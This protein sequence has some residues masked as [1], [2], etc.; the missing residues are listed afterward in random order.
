MTDEE[1]LEKTFEQED[2]DPFEGKD[3]QV[4][5]P[6]NSDY[7]LTLDTIESLRP[8][9]TSKPNIRKQPFALLFSGPADTPLDNALYRL[10][11]EG[12]EPYLLYID[13][14]DIDEETNR[15][16]YEAIVN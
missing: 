9:E 4:A 16:V 10:T 11:P 6:G 14:K 3:F 2:L 15:V 8:N 5:L 7:H 12:G 1:L 13:K